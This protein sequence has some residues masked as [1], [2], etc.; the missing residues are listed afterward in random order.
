M[1]CSISIRIC[2]PSPSD[3]PRS[4]HPLKKRRLGTAAS[5]WHC[6][7]AAAVE[8]TFVSKVYG[9]LRHRDRESEREQDAAVVRRWQRRSR[10][11]GTQ[12][13]RRADEFL[14]S[15]LVFLVVIYRGSQSDKRLLT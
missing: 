7:V 13:R 10:A 15:T 6:A 11:T 1:A 2:P 4:Q 3:P 9:P 14:C 8:E 5:V 12:P